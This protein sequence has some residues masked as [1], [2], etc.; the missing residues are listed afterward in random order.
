VADLLAQLVAQGID[1]KQSSPGQHYVPCPRCSKQRKAGHQNRPCLSVKIDEDGAVWNCH[2]CGW[3]GS[4]PSRNVHD[5]G[6]GRITNGA[7]STL[8]L[9]PPSPEASDWLRGRLIPDDVQQ[10]YRI[11]GVKRK[12]ENGLR[13]TVAR[14]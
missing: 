12:F 1:L 5:Q 11:G 2:H 3:K 8:E 13:D 9:Y 4:L 10:R 7:S 14:G 6:N